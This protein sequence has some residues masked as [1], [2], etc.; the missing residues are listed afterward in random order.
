M[1][2]LTVHLVIFI[3]LITFT[4]CSSQNSGDEPEAAAPPSSRGTPAQPPPA[5]PVD[6][7]V[8]EVTPSFDIEESDDPFAGLSFKNGWAR[9]PNNSTVF[10]GYGADQ[11]ND[12]TAGGPGM[13]AVGFNIRN[14]DLDANVWYSEDGIRWNRVESEPELGGGGTQIMN[15]VAA[16]DN[17]VVAVG[18]ETIDNKNNAAVWFSKDGV[19]WVRIPEIGTT[20]GDSNNQIMQHVTAF[21]NGF[22]AVGVEK[23]DT[24]IRGAVWLSPN[25]VA[26]QRVSHT[27]EAFGGQNLFVSLE[28]V[29]SV[30]TSL[31]AAGTVQ[32]PN[33]D[34][35]DASVWVSQDEGESWTRMSSSENA[36]GDQDAIRYQ[37]VS[38]ITRDNDKFLMIGTEQ[39]TSAS[40]SDQYINGIIWKSAD[41]VSWERVYDHKPDYHQQTMMDI[42]HTEL[43]FVIVGYDQVGDQAQAAAWISPDGVNW[44]QVPHFESVFGGSGPQRM[45]AITGGGPGFVAVG[46]TFENGE[47]DTAVWIYVPEK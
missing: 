47:Q 37:L 15:A 12:V 44:T 45:N 32:P 28:E 20:F 36:L 19:N 8:I 42:I 35:V 14:G 2:K 5:P 16:G 41:G 22:V 24:E 38:A 43:G 40:T 18:F 10:G 1:K 34:D 39:N 17:G 46:T 9:I 3:I 23:T 33:Q 31:I 21:D 30:G 13:V 25:G 4:A 29:M 27:E 26:W 7:G 6:D 11:M